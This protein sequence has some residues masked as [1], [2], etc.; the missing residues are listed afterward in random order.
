MCH[1]DGPSPDNTDGWQPEDPEA[2]VCPD[3]GLI[4]HDLSAHGIAVRRYDSDYRLVER[5]VHWIGRDQFSLMPDGSGRTASGEINF[6]DAFAFAVPADESTVTETIRGT[7]SKAATD[8]PPHQ[9][10]FL[11]K[12]ELRFT[13]DGELQILSGRW[14]FADDFT[15]AIQRLCAALR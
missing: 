14:D 11:N 1:G 12:G 3:G 6:F 4:Y 8:Q 10:V 15:G 9:L 5:V 7:D 13:P 2:W